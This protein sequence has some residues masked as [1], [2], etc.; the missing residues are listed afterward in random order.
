MSRTFIVACLLLAALA[1]ACS[2]DDGN[3]PP[4]SGTVSAPAS[5]SPTTTL[6]PGGGQTAPPATQPAQTDTKPAG[7]AAQVI[8]YGDTSRKVVA[9][10]FDAGSDAGYTASILDTLSA[11]GVRVSFGM[12]GKWAE[13]NPDLLRRMVAD[14]H[15][16]IN[17]TYDH[18]SFTGNSSQADGL[19]EAQRWDELNRTEQIIND[20]T[21]ATTRPYFRPPYG[22]YDQSVNEDVGALGYTYNVMWAIDS[23]GWTG[24]PAAQIA[25]RCIDLAEPGAIYVLHVGSASED[26]PALQS[27]IDGLHA[28]GYEITDLP[29][30]LE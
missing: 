17:H 14:G 5:P 30:V 3:E 13:T 19:S 22:D 25:Q 28:E 24:I 11:N 27:I 15:T 7:V 4:P 10:S 29:G 2:G 21:G 20:L 1:V 18:R 12:T 23:R 26:G 8:R 6:A 16:L 9:F